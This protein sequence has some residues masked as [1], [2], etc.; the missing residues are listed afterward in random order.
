MATLNNIIGLSLALVLSACGF[1]LR[2]NVNL[3]DGVEPIYIGGLSANNQLSIALR[4]LLTANNV[5]L[6]TEADQAKYQLIILDQSTDRRTIGLGESARATE[7]QLIETVSFELRNKQG[8][9]VIGPVKITERKIMPNDPNQIV[10]SSAEEKILR[11][12]ILQSLAAKIARQLQ[13]FDY[14][15]ILAPN[16]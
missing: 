5:D 4:N 13:K 1:H 9:P 2:G 7:Y 14:P 16:S 8:I 6:S 3:P 11:R 10:S 15:S 12:E